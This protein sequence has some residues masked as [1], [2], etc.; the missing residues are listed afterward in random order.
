MRTFIA[1]EIPVLPKLKESL[2]NVKVDL[3]NERI[4]WVNFSTLHLTLF[5]LGETSTNQIEILKDMMCKEFE[6]ISKFLL[7]LSGLGVFG[8]KNN[9]KV[10]WIGVKQSQSLNDCYSKIV[11]IVKSLGFKEDE[12]GFNPHITIGR[13][14]QIED[15]SLLTELIDEQQN[16]LYQQSVIDKIILYKS[17]LTPQGPIYTPLYSGY[18][19]D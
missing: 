4:K 15:L 7:L 16:T 8:S 9:P 17:E 11:K 6:G 19:K 5:F 13:M 12:R 14:N 18:L 2:I 10:I 1:L 3:S